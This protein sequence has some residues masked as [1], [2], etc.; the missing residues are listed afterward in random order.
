MPQRNH[1]RPATLAKV[2]FDFRGELAGC[3]FLAEQAKGRRTAARHERGEGPM[4]AQEC[5]I[6]FQ[7]RV[8]VQD[9]NL[10]RVVQERGGWRE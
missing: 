3:L 8:L 6:Q 10:K 5:L 2:T 7:N 9:W 4:L 1:G